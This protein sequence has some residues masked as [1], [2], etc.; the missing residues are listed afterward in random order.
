MVRA[1]QTVDL[2]GRHFLILHLYHVV[3]LQSHYNPGAHLGESLS[4]DASR[5]VPSSK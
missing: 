2:S 1:L 4:R 3:D 5:R